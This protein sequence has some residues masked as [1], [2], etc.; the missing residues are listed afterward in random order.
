MNRMSGQGSHMGVQEG[1]EVDE[2]GRVIRGPCTL[3]NG[4]V[5]SGQWLNGIRDG[6]GS[7]MWPDGSRYEGCW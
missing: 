4:A 7:Q 6:Y 2:N 1:E 3:K 5:Y